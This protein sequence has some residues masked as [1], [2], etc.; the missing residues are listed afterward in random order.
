MA[1]YVQQDAHE[2]LIA[3]L[4]S[5]HG[6]FKGTVKLHTEILNWNNY[7]N[8][9]CLGEVNGSTI[10]KVD[11]NCQCIIHQIFAGNLQSDVT[12]QNCR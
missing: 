3:I 10:E 7:I 9:H 6:H 12:C 2:F 5:L 8:N 4:N 1:G 11:D